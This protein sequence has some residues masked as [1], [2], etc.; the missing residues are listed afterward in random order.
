[1]R[2]QRWRTF[3]EPI[4]IPSTSTYNA[5]ATTCTAP[6]TSYKAFLPDSSQKRT[7]KRRTKAR[8]V[9]RLSSD[10]APEV[11]G[12]RMGP[13]T[14]AQTGWWPGSDI[15]GRPTA[16]ERY[17]L[18][19][20][21]SFDAARLFDRRWATTLLELALQRLA[22]EQAARGRANQF[23]DLRRF[24]VTEG[25]SKGMPRSLSDSGSRSLPRAWPFPACASVTE[26]CCARKSCEPSPGSGC[27]RGIS[28][29][30]GRIS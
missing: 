9:P 30:D 27:R 10:L 3:A 12:R 11:P 18:E 28:L 7:L 22:E 2:P 21:D 13:R 15:V 17:K 20:V 19:P 14:P 8:Q 5:G 23:E 29:A 6:K 25:E 16:E 26:N 1:M 24:L 4:G